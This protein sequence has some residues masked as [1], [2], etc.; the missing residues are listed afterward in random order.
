MADPAG[1]DETGLGAEHTHEHTLPWG[2]RRIEIHTL[3]WA[4][5]LSKWCPQAPRSTPS[6]PAP[7]GCVT[8]STP[9]LNAAGWEGTRNFAC[10]SL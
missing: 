2:Q 7:S 4:V 5:P 9:F 6:P 1:K 8:P 3:G 10:W